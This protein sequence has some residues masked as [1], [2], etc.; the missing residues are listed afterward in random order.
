[1]AETSNPMSKV[2]RFSL[3]GPI[4]T[5]IFL[6]TRRLIGEEAGR[7]LLQLNDQLE[8]LIPNWSVYSDNNYGLE[9]NV[10]TRREGI[11]KPPY[12]AIA[13]FDKDEA[14]PIERN[15]RKSLSNSQVPA[16]LESISLTAIHI[17]FFYFGYATF[18]A[19]F[20]LSGKYHDLS[21][22]NLRR[23]VETLSRDEVIRHFE[24]LFI[25]RIEE[26]RS[27]ARAVKGDKGESVE[28]KGEGQPKVRNEQ[29]GASAKPRWVHRIY[30]LQ[31]EDADAVVKSSSRIE[32]LIFTS[33][34]TELEN[35]YSRSGAYIYV[36]SGN[37][38]L[39]SV[40][41]K[42]DLPWQNL[43]EMVEFQNA[44]FARAE[45][46]DEHLL[47]LV[48]RISLDKER[49][50]HNRK[51]M[52]EMDSYATDIVD[53]REEVLIFKNDVSDYEGH[54]DPDAKKIWTGLWDQ[55]DTGRKFDQIE[56]QV[57]ITGGL[58]DRIITLLHQNQTKRLSS[59]A[60]LFTLISGLSAFVDTCSFTQGTPLSTSSMDMTNTIVIILVI[61]VL[62]FIFWLI[63]RR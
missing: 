15:I 2:I 32:D 41:T 30:G 11:V 18:C 10:E 50:R 45:D 58:Y 43:N 12:L 28:W 39:F 49:V 29:D 5:G 62:A 59:F 31:F 47:R 16:L 56:R 35:L 52:R 46:L 40:D 22:D 4:R 13:S 6:D 36:S 57:D 24:E 44:F 54:L 19:K 63:M 61:L 55:W 26:F 33:S 34:N 7:I 1:M 51:L 21:L 53:S 23:G 8:P 48:N 14:A 60:L 42:A 3:N 20:R 27:A 25:Q 38:A 37:S 17:R 9:I